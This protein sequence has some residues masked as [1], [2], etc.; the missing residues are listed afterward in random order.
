MPGEEPFA[1][2][3]TGRGASACWENS[4]TRASVRELLTVDN[5]SGAEGGL[6][7]CAGHQA[8]CRRQRRRDDPVRQ[9][10]G[11]LAQSHAP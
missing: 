2:Y 3:G 11:H 8:A 9:W 7:R 1:Y 4:V 6:R 5:M 10:A